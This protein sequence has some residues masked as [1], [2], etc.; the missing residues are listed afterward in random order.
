MLD[1]SH[2][3]LKILEKLGRHITGVLIIL[4]LISTNVLAVVLDHTTHLSLDSP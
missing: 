4:T 1:A 2:A 3:T